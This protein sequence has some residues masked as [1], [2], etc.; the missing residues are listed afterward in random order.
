MNIPVQCDECKVEE[1]RI[2]CF[3]VFFEE[4]DGHDGIR[5]FANCPYCGHGQMVNFV[6]IFKLAAYKRRQNGHPDL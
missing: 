6:S 3:E 5:F 4:D 1:M 2:E